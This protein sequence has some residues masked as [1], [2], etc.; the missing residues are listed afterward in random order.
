M[1][2]LIDSG[3]FWCWAEQNK[4]KLEFN[5]IDRHAIPLYPERVES[6]TQKVALI[7]DGRRKKIDS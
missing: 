4:E 3:D 5:K 7:K 2:K 6:D 1:N